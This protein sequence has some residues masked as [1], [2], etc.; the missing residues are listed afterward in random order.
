MIVKKMPNL[1]GFPDIEQVLFFL[2][3]TLG[4]EPVSPVFYDVE[5]TGLSRNASFLYLIGAV[6]REEQQW[7]LYQ[8]FGENQEEE[9]SLLTAFSQFLEKYDCTIQYNG[10]SFDQP[11]LEHKYQFHGLP[12]PFDGK[13]SLDLYKALKPLKNLLKLP[14]MKQPDLEAFLHIPPRTFCDGAQC[15]ALYKKYIKTNDAALG[16]CVMG[17]NREDL[18]GLGSIFFMTNYLCLLE[19][20]YEIPESGYLDASAKLIL[21]LRLPLF[22]PAA[23]SNG[24]SRF[25]FSADKDRLNI[26]VQ[27]S[28]G[29]LRQYYANYRDYDYLPGEDT[30]IP[31]VLSAYIDKS[32]KQKATPQNCYTWFPVTEEFLNDKA[33]LQKY[34]RQS[35]PILLK[36]II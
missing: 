13:P 15:I 19:G 27:T 5:T 2:D 23:V 32:L 34:A 7:V 18:A 8:W 22:L 30:A 24:D 12:S 11:Y 28:D 31:K 21:S 10:D 14:R 29:Q 6:V 4:T 9:L 20:D 36:L 25:Y 17:H 35:I 16:D 33:G 26:A 1:Q 3:K